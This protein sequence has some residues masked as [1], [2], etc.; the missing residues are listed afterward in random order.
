MNY[1]ANTAASSA[2]RWWQD[3]EVY[4]IYVRSFCDSNGDGIG[5]LRGIISKLDYLEKLGVNALWLTPVY[6]SPMVDNGYDVSDYRAI[7]PVF[8][9]MADMDALISAAASHGIKI[10]M[11]LVINHT[12]DRH[13]WFTASCKGPA[14]QNPYSDYYIWR[15]ARPDGSAPNNWRS[16]F[17]GSAWT[18]NAE[19][20]QYYLHTFAP[21]QPDLNWANPA[22]RREIS[23][24]ANFW[25][26]KGV[27]GFRIDAVPYI[28][29]PSDF[30]D[31]IPDSADGSVSI[32]NMTVNTPGILDYLREFDLSLKNRDNIFTVGEANG[33]SASE[34]DS[35]V[36]GRGVFD[37]L[38][39][40]THLADTE[41]WYK[42]SFPDIFS[43]RKALNDSEKAT[44]ADGWYPVFFENHDRPRCQNVYFD[45]N[46]A[47]FSEAASNDT[48]TALCNAASMVIGTI[49]YTMRGTPF[50]YQG[51]ELGMTNTVW[52][53][54]EC[55]DVN[56]TGQ[57][58]LALANGYTPEQAMEF[59]NRCS[60]DN[61]RTPMQWNASA[62]AGFTSGTP[63]IKLNP[64]YISVNAEAEENDPGS[65]L[66][67][68]RRLSRLRHDSDILT[69]GD[70]EPLLTDD[71][72]IFGYLR[73]LGEKNMLVLNNM[74]RS[75]AQFPASLTA[76]FSLIMS[77]AEPSA[78]PAKSVTAA[79]ASL[80]SAAESPASTESPSAASTFASNVCNAPA[81]YGSTLLPLES[82][83]Y[84]K[85]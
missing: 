16:I 29:K 71:R 43:L 10:V 9:S 48:C 22:V 18:W 2:H 36:G 49:L 13:S 62:G 74:S 38:F 6:A 30:S 83:I 25:L 69:Q 53:A 78:A 41:I 5:D 28:K 77:S 17:G 84:L 57:Y 14:H 3:G 26:N 73:R 60:R 31:G 56:F 85:L 75:E 76:G 65:V 8:G 32:H 55:M 66:S 33:V 34:L 51:Q 79:P 12:S 11:D 81:S 61:A 35:W 50:I 82:R 19:R 44:S 15:D 64:N 63:W 20:G 67:W 58:R 40:F 23:D 27:G 46:G 42:P 59:A 7:D 70:Y 24:I 1:T 37:M 72:Q 45:F 21:E 68:F 80:L 47:A 52:Q 4:E 54:E 39:Q